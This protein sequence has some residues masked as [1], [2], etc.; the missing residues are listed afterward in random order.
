MQEIRRDGSEVLTQVFEDEAAEK[1]K[2]ALAKLENQTVA[3]HKPGAIF[4]SRGKWYHVMENGNLAQVNAIRA[5]KILK[6]NKEK[7]AER[8]DEEG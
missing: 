6:V 3:I 7:L 2:E 5:R 1:L 4:K 8:M